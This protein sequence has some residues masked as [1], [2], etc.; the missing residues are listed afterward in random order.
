LTMWVVW[1]SQKVHWF[2]YK[3]YNKGVAYSEKLIV[4]YKLL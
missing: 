4:H 1:R 2:H 3:L